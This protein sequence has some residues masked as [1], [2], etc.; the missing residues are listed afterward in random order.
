MKGFIVLLMLLPFLLTGCGKTET[1][2]TD[3]AVTDTIAPTEAIESGSVS[4][5][6]SETPAT[7]TKETTPADASAGAG[8]GDN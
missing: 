8:D 1:T 2:S 4:P 3:T 5:S 6:V 7:N